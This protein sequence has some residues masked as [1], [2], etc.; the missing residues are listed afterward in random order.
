MTAINVNELLLGAWLRQ[1]HITHTQRGVD[2]KKKKQ[3]KKTAAGHLAL[4][5][6]FGAGACVILH[7]IS[8]QFKLNLN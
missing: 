6:P 8:K 1:L 7:Y 5:W 3:K 2:Q 4:A